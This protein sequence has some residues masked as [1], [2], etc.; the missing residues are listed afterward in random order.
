MVVSAGMVVCLMSDVLCSHD[1]DLYCL[2]SAGLG[3][4]GSVVDV[5]S[6]C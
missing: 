5:G 1:V 2:S 6:S 3:V 4:V